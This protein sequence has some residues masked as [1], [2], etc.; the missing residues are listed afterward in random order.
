MT[1]AIKPIDTQ[2]TAATNMQW[3][4]DEQLDAQEIHTSEKQTEEFHKILNEE[5]V[6]GYQPPSKDKMARLAL[7]L[8]QKNLTI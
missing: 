7:I 4:A 5:T 3:I 1:E 8:A 6:E 2:A